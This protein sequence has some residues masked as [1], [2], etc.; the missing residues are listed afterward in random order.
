M[1]NFVSVWCPTIRVLGAGRRAIPRGM[2]I[3][4]DPLPLPISRPFSPAERAAIIVAIRA[5]RL[6]RVPRGQS[7]L[8][9]LTG[10]A[11]GRA[12]IRLSIG[13]AIMG[14]RRLRPGS[15]VERV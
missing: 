11:G 13:A 1:F 6:Q 9:E 3:P 8:P 15:P 7:G 4:A 14:R 2:Q 12:A 10:H 5:G